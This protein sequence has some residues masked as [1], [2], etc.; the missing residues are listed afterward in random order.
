[1]ALS[2]LDMASTVPLDADLRALF[3]RLED[4]IAFRK[5]LDG[6]PASSRKKVDD[7][8]K[9]RL[10]EVS[11]IVVKLPQLLAC[12]ALLQR[13]ANIREQLRS[14]SYV[15]W[16]TLIDTIADSFVEIA[17]KSESY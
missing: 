10:Y 17:L 5:S 11:N 8:I 3:K 13:Y 7:A 15:A 4:L 2:A 12:K 14:I 6:L 16:P 9:A 1:M